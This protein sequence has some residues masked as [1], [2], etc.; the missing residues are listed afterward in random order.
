[1]NDEAKENLAL[2]RR[3]MDESKNIVIDNGIY[4][5]FWSVFVLLGSGLTYLLRYLKS[6]SLINWVWLALLVPFYIWT[7]LYHNK[8]R[9]TVTFS[10][11][12]YRSVNLGLGAV[13]G[14]PFFALL[15]SG[16]FD[17]PV[18]LSFV[19]AVMGSAKFISGYIIKIKWIAVISV[20]W[21]AFSFLFPL[22]TADF[23]LLTLSIAFT[24]LELIPGL[25]IYFRWKRNEV[26]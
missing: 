23:A 1:M 15:I 12:V 3:M 22:I 20:G 13:I 16:K 10:M 17:I 19:C 2:I 11:R 24:L 9:E 6:Y 7:V 14:V 8:R 21:F 18:F 5:I 26:K 4:R 25:F